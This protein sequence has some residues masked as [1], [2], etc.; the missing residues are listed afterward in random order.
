MNTQENVK[1]Y[2]KVGG[3][4]DC[5]GVPFFYNQ[6][7]NASVCGFADAQVLKAWAGVE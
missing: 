2:E 3:V 5:G 6:E 1:L 4:R 7:N